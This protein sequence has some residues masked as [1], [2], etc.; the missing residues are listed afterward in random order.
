MIEWNDR[1]VHPDEKVVQKVK[2]P[3]MS[4]VFGNVVKN[5]TMKASKAKL[6]AKKQNLS[7]GPHV[8][9]SSGFREFIADA[10]KRLDKKR[11]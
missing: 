10:S 7:E 8:E 6:V 4:A 5:K 3:V 11:K 1:R 9:D 2:A